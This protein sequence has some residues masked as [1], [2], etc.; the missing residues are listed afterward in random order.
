VGDRQWH[1]S[2]LRLNTR[3]ALKNLEQ[4][5]LYHIGNDELY[6]LD[7][8]A[9]AFLKQCDGSRRGVDLAG[10]DE[11]VEFCLEEGLLDLLPR[12]DRADVSVR[13]APFPSLRYLELQLLH[14]CNLRCRH[15]YIGAP[16][17]AALLLEDAVALAR[18]FSSFGGLRLMV[19]GGEPL[20]YPRLR[21][22]VERTE[23]LGVRRILLTNGTLITRENIGW[24][25]FEQI[26][27]S[28]DG[29]RSG[30][31]ML[32]GEGSFDRVLAGIALAR[33]EGI[34]VSLATMIHRGNLDEF[35]ELHRFAKE[36]DA[37]EWGVDA[38]CIAGRLQ[39][40]SELTVTPEEAAP[41]MAYAYGGGYHG[42]SDG[43]ACGRHLMTVMPTG[44][45]VKCGFYEEPSLGNAREGL[46]GCWLRLRHVPL[47]ELECKGCPVLAECAGGCRFRA[48]RPLAPDEVMCAL[49]GVG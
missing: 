20:L 48:S 27:F 19:S 34:P 26:Q 11:F 45:A 37:V 9:F 41:L 24:L 12:P 40:D 31:E 17:P 4:P 29:W 36:I 49:H 5:Y 3:V 16:R 1:D 38:L 44:G 46:L 14:D 7:G 30:H 35:H 21:E 6:E 39:A 25:G 33:E 13:T 47:D 18:E 15:C 28:L 42:P 10:D 32:R 23:G 43:F 8:D 22:F 2:F